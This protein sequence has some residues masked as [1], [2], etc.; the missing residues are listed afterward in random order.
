M[1]GK[2]KFAGSLGFLL[3]GKR[4]ATR[5]GSP[6]EAEAAAPR[7]Y[8][9]DP[10]A[11]TEVRTDVPPDYDFSRDFDPDAHLSTEERE[12]RSNAEQVR[13]EA[14]SELLDPDE[15]KLRPLIEYPDA[16]AAAAAAREKAAR[17]RDMPWLTGSRPVYHPAITVESQVTA[18]RGTQ[19]SHAGPEA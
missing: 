15:V 11:P 2:G 7:R 5:N 1:P 12:H 17:L 19:P 14:N 9:D 4:A 18:T 10:N 8:S 3:R 6:T 16:E 13:R